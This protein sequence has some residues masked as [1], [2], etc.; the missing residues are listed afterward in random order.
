MIRIIRFY[1]QVFRV[2]TDQGVVGVS[3]LKLRI[4]EELLDWILLDTLKL[5]I[6]IFVTVKSLLFDNLSQGFLLHS[7]A[8][9]LRQNAGDE[10]LDEVFRA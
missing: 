5:F 4:R 2:K 3:A 10:S 6:S 8:W 7:R 9:L 1:G